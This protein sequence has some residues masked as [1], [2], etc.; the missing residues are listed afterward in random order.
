MIVIL[1]VARIIIQ[2]GRIFGLFKI[3]ITGAPQSGKS[4]LA[5]RA[6]DDLL[7]RYGIKSYL[8]SEVAS[9]L[10]AGGFD[11]KRK[12]EQFQTMLY[13]IQ[14]E[15]EDCFAGTAADDSIIIMDRGLLDGKC[16]MDEDG[17]ERILQ[18]H[19]DT[20]QTVLNRYDAV[21][22]LGTICVSD[23]VHV[24]NE[25]N[26]NR[27]ETSDSEVL[28]LEDKLIAVYMHHPHYTFIPAE[29]DIEVKYDKLL[30]AI[31]KTLREKN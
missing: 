9:D 31:I 3:C 13:N 30:S 4:Q 25:S 16:Y 7:E 29:D 14:K 17:F 19:G 27:V 23:G 8:V 5:Q 26:P 15:K 20:T 1:W 6:K 11:P 10:I 24:E 2:R 28:E 22:Q 21:I 12:K 18:S